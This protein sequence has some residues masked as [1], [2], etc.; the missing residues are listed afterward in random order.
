MHRVFLC[1]MLGV[2]FIP[3]SANAEVYRDIMDLEI[4]SSQELEGRCKTF[5]E[6]DKEGRLVTTIIGNAVKDKMSGQRNNSRSGATYSHSI[7]LNSVSDNRDIYVHGL[8]LKEDQYASVYR[9]LID[10]IYKDDG[11]T[12]FGLCA[13][14]V[15]VE[16]GSNSLIGLIDTFVKIED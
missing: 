3:T 9:P 10:L 11:R 5:G 14:S 6:S 7:V 16:E 2:L 1:L 13:Y 15:A 12:K 4:I 8:L